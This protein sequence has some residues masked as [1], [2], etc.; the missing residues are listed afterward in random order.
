MRAPTNRSAFMDELRTILED[1]A[2]GHCQRSWMSRRYIGNINGI[3]QYVDFTEETAPQLIDFQ[4]YGSSKK[5]CIEY[6][7]NSDGLSIRVDGEYMQSLRFELYKNKTTYA[8]AV[9]VWVDRYAC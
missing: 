2:C 1:V 8:A 5:V 3:D 4:H 6:G 9:A 7:A